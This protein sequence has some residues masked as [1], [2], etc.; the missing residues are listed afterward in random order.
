MTRQSLLEKQDVQKDI[1]DLNTEIAE[2]EEK[3]LDLVCQ[4]NKLR[5][6][7]IN[8]QDKNISQL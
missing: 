4:H 3:Y 8:Q 6:K 2:L 1:I 7:K 5:A